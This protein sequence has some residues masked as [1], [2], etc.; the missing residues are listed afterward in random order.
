MGCCIALWRGAAPFRLVEEESCVMERCVNLCGLKWPAAK[1]G[2]EDGLVALVRSIVREASF[3]GID[4]LYAGSSFCAAA[5]GHSAGRSALASLAR[6]CEALH[7]P[8]TLTVPAATE[9]E[10]PAL[11]RSMEN[12]LALCPA[13]DEVTVNDYGMLDWMANRTALRL[14]IGRLFSRDLRDPR[15]EGGFPDCYRPALIPEALEAIMGEYSQV[16]GIEL[17][18]AGLTVDIS[19]APA[20]ATVA[21]HVPYLFATTGK[22]CSVAPAR[23]GGVPASSGDACAQECCGSMV[24]HCLFPQVQG[25]APAEGGGQM[26]D[27][28]VGE[29]ARELYYLKRGKTVYVLN[30]GVRVT[31]QRP[32]RLVYTPRHFGWLLEGE[33]A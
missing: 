1:T 19:A 2:S 33:S 27:G 11:K 12:A 17:D 5:F 16:G 13:I 14:N 32:Y 28:V 3:D 25:D 18:P 22:H 21:V 24:T 8:C 10:L 9:I 7:V 4:R 15:Y 29:G 31:G 23:P 6:A 20:L 30:D 26:G